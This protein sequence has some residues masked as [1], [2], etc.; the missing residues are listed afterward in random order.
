DF[1]NGEKLKGGQTVTRETPVDIMPLYIKV[2]TIL[3]LGPKVQYAN[4]K[5][6]PTEIR[7]YTGANGKFTL[8]DDEKDNYNYEKGNYA[9]VEFSWNDNDRE[10]TI[11]KRK[12]TFEGMLK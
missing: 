5:I 12:G 7:I 8:Y 2:G 3:P 4:E 6:D 11:E 10:L 9:T 1:W